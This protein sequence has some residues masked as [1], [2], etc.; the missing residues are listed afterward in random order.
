MVT[1]YFYFIFARKLNVSIKHV[2]IQEIY[3]DCL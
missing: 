3:F 1:A 2:R